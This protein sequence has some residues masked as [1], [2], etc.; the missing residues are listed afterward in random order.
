MPA[1]P[2]WRS[3]GLAC[4]GVAIC[5]GILYFRAPAHAQKPAPETFATGTAIVE[6]L[7]DCVRA[8][9]NA[10]TCP[11]GK[12]KFALRAYLDLPTIAERVGGNTWQNSAAAD[13]E[14]FLDLI[15]ELIEQEVVET[16]GDRSVIVKDERA[17][18]SGDLLVT[19]E[20]TAKTDQTTRLSW[21]IGRMPDRLLVRDISIDGISLVVSARDQIQTLAG[22]SDGSLDS[23]AAIIRKRY[24]RTIKR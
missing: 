4:L 21:L 24:V 19:G 15:A 7:H 20:Y 14:R 10:D 11:I 9:S 8:K 13:R 5:V 16:F 22:E 18:P 17:L 1:R 6:F 2:A 3:I 12:D 23:L